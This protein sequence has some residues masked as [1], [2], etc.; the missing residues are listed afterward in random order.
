MIHHDREGPLDDD[1]DA[2]DDNDEKDSDDHELDRHPGS[3]MPLLINH[4][5]RHDQRGR[6]ILVAAANS[7]STSAAYLI[8]PPTKLHT[9]CVQ[10]K[11]KEE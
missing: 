4:S 8:G 3:T 5:R 1:N 7:A 10:K 6:H 9:I 2:N 11:K